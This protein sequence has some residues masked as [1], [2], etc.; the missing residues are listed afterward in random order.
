[1][2]VK[3]RLAKKVSLAKNRVVQERVDYKKKMYDKY[4]FVTGGDNNS[5]MDVLQEQ[6]KKNN[7]NALAKFYAAGLEVR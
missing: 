2:P 1:M 7:L 5:L 3:V 6:L 4:P